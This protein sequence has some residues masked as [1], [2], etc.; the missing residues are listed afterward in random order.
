M[1][2]ADILAV[3]LGSDGD[4]TKALY[5]RLAQVGPAGEIALNLF[6][7]CKCSERAKVYRGGIRGKGSFRKMAYNR[8]QWSMDNL[9]KTLQVHG[10]GFCWGWKIDHAQ[11]HHRWVLYV[12]IPT[13]Q[14]SF[15]CAARGEGPDYPGEWD[16]SPGNAPAR[17]CRW[18]EQLLENISSEVLTKAA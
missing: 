6:R 16:R 1:R 17:I 12:E 18:C 8:K 11:A 7:A 3:Y 4:A 5:D 13:G 10:A 9:S 14:I 2:Y 15:H